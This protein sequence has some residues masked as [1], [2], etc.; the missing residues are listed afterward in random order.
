[1]NVVYIVGQSSGGLPHYTAQLANE[2][3]DEAE[4][5]VLKPDETSADGLFDERV[6][7]QS[8]FSSIEL[9]MPKIYSGELHPAKILAGIRSYDNLKLVHELEP[10]LIHDTTGLFPHVKLFSFW[11]EI[12]DIAP[13]VITRHE[14]PETRFSVS[15]PVELAE[16]LVNTVIPEVD[17]AGQVVHTEFQKEALVRRGVSPSSIR[18][19]PHGAYSVFGD[20]HDIDRQPEECCLLFFGH[21]VPH[22]GVDTLVDAVALLRDEF[23]DI[24]L[25]IAGDG[26]IPAEAQATINQWPENFEVHNY[27]VPNDRVEDL[28]SRAQIIVLPYDDHLGR[29]K[30]HSGALATA[31]SFGK[32]V[33]TSQ[34]GD[35]PRLVGDTGCGR[36][37]PSGDPELLA[38]T[39]ASLFRYPEIRESMA[40][41]SR[42]L[43]QKL[44]W[45]N[46]AKEYLEVYRSVVSKHPSLAR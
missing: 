34:A 12:A 29:T 25:I 18:V 21:I 43:A 20:Y 37:V 45:E 3:V 22:K 27:Y 28:F 11:H 13:F 17:T 4:V 42:R 15:R 40:A 6:H 2:M 39:I 35:F 7:L 16:E 23:P 41:E 24:S 26:Q 31:L 10:D 8:V 32:P 44:S 30:G 38:A 46:I 9:S 5:T 36:T 19:I 1:M 14:V 33:V